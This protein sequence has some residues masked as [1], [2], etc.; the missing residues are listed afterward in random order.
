MWPRALSWE[1]WSW[2]GGTAVRG[3]WGEHG[4]SG[5]WEMGP[6]APQLGVLLGSALISL[7]AGCD[8]RLQSGLQG[9]STSEQQQHT[10]KMR[11]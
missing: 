11:G 7:L 5:P 9:A 6:G 1:L 2:G 3:T 10:D 8:L 4:G